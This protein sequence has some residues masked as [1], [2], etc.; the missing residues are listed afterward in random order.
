MDHHCVPDCALF[1]PN[2]TS[3]FCP[4]K[5]RLFQEQAIKTD[6]ILI[7]FPLT[8]D[9]LSGFSKCTAAA[10]WLLKIARYLSNFSSMFKWITSVMQGLLTPHHCK[11]W[12]F[13]FAKLCGIKIKFVSNGLAYCCY[14]IIAAMPDQSGRSKSWNPVLSS[15]QQCNEDYLFNYNCIKE[16]KQG[17]TSGTILCCL[18][19]STRHTLRC[20]TEWLLLHQH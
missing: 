7:M 11:N 15:A 18:P 13:H 6:H 16:L 14:I 1:G 10:K 4:C 8:S 17:M 5:L 19:S 20:A 9:I 2:E 12:P 3:I